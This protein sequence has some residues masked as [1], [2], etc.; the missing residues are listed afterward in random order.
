MR[1]T[2]RFSGQTVPRKMD[3]EGLPRGGCEMVSAVVLSFSDRP[4]S[5]TDVPK[6]SLSNCQ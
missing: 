2:V 1:E 3:G 4:K 6:P 5:G